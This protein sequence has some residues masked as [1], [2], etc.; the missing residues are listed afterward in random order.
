MIVTS[1]RCRE[2]GGGC[3]VR[4][5]VGFGPGVGD[6]VG[7]GARAGLSSSPAQGCIQPSSQ[8][9]L[10]SM[11][12]VLLGH[13]ATHRQLAAWPGMT[14]RTERQAMGAGGG[15]RVKFGCAAVH[16]LAVELACK[17]QGSA[18]C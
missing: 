10:P 12:P 2:E 1:K 18:Q 14:G 5:E 15:M 11:L 16:M 17:I 8:V 7:W 3:G 4:W 13:A 6:G 9:R